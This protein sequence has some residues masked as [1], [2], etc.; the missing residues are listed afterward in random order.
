MNKCDL[1]S[2]FF[3]ALIKSRLRRNSVSGVNISESIIESVDG[4]KGEV[5]SF[6]ENRF[7]EV[8]WERPTLDGIPF[9]VL[10][11]LDMASLE[12]LTMEKLKEA[13]WDSEG[14][15]CSGPDDIN[16]GFIKQC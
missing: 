8:S 9:K 5:R 1:N 11:K 2:R 4:V 16:V 12:D 6:F 15:T 7:V 14:D 13:M 10:Y 3:H